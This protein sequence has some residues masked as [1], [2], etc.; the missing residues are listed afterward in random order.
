MLEKLKSIY[1]FLSPRYQTLFLDYQVAFRPRFPVGKPH[2]ELF[3]IINKGRDR[4]A[5]HLQ[6]IL[7]HQPVLQAIS[8]T[9][10]EA[11]PLH[12]NYNNGFFP[13]LDLVALYS[14]L[15]HYQPKQ[16][17]EVGSGNS[18]KVAAKAVKD[19]G[20]DTHITSIDPMP[21]AD[22][23]QLAHTVIRE[24]LENTDLDRFSQLEA[25]DIL[26]I[27]NSHR[28][29]PN[30]D[31]TVVFLELLPRL[32]PGVVVHIHD[33]YLPY[34]YPQFMADRFYSEQYLLATWLLANPDSFEVLMPNF[35]ISEEKDLAGI[36]DPLWNHPNLQGVEQH[37]GSFWMR[38]N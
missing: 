28:C 17:W 4:Y 20:L 9:P 7:K 3:Q 18:T 16:Y 6:N 33:I 37:G 22:I 34:D 14:L 10:D 2:P 31:V 12:P 8:K 1:R 21:R 36:L 35:F 32:K 23:D 11:N 38:K 30:S 27:D 5:E 29:L 25:N 24:P 13:G 15:G 19:L 26:F